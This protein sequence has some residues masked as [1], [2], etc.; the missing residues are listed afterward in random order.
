[1]PLQ[2]SLV[3]AVAAPLSL[4]AGAYTSLSSSLLSVFANLLG[5]IPVV[6]STL[7]RFADVPAYALL[8]VAGNS[9]VVWPFHFAARY[10]DR[11]PSGWW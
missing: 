9:L 2:S 3:E 10:M 7:A 11:H 5:S 4:L 1:M 8:F 6:G